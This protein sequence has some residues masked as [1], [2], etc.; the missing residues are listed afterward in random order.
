MIAATTMA[1]GSDRIVEKIRIDR[2]VR[3]DCLYAKEGTA[4][5]QP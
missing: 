4:G 1:N 5:R 3:I 2:R